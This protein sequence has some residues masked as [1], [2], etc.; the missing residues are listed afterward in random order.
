MSSHLTDHIK[1][2]HS[3]DKFFCDIEGCDFFSPSKKYLKKHKKFKHGE[4]TFMCAICAK[5]FKCIQKLNLHNKLIHHTSHIDKHKCPEC[6]KEFN[7]KSNMKK[8][9]DGVHRK[10]WRFKCDHCEKGFFSTKLL[11]QH[12]LK[13]HGQKELT[14]YLLEKHGEK[15]DGVLQKYEFGTNELGTSELGTSELG[16]SELVTRTIDARPIVVAN[17]DI[18]GNQ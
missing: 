4:A 14:Q 15:A 17:L 6:S 2:V 12:L 16:T 8:H 13:K 7:L 5:K 1:N 10:N 18:P 11:T 9:V 3:T